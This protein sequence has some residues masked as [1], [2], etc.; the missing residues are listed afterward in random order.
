MLDAVA[1]RFSEHAE[2][3]SYHISLLEED[4]RW[5]RLA[6][7]SSPRAADGD[8]PL[9]FVTRTLPDTVQPQSL[10]YSM[11]AANLGED[12]HAAGLLVL[13]TTPEMATRVAEYAM[14][15][16]AWLETSRRDTQREGLG[17]ERGP[18]STTG[19]VPTRVG[20]YQVLTR[21][22]FLRKTADYHRPRKRRYHHLRCL[23]IYR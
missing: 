21:L 23:H 16:S 3:K 18:T 19:K 1:S 11:C 17:V 15:L 14:Q 2:I 6:L 10:P 4:D 9:R 22:W 12:R 20:R 5:S 7:S 8:Q 13:E